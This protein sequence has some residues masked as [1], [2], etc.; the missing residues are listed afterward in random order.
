MPMASR[1]LPRLRFHRET[2]MDFALRLRPDS[3]ILQ[4][5]PGRAKIVDLVRRWTDSPWRVCLFLSQ[6]RAKVGSL[7][8]DL[9]PV[10]ES[11]FRPV[12]TADFFA[13]RFSLA[14]G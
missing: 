11:G 12:A 10:M 7:A 1:F 6:A 14:P 2:A 9:D 4:A 8:F 13:A 5:V 3:A